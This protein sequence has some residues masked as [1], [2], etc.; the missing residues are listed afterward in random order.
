MSTHHDF[1]EEKGKID[2]LT[3]KGYVIK[4]VTENLNGSSV[5]FEKGEE[6]GNLIEM[7]QIENADARKYF[8]TLIISQR[9]TR[10]S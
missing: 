2:F 5:V 6:T 4:K 7:L 8:A 10:L 9:K 1:L 3:E